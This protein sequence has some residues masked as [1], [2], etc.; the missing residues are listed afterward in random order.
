MKRLLYIIWS[1]VI[2]VTQLFSYCKNLAWRTP[3]IE[4]FLI[5]KPPLCT[6]PLTNLYTTGFGF[7]IKTSSDLCVIKGHT[8]Y[9]YLQMGLR[10]HFLSTYVIKMYVKIYKSFFLTIGW[11]LKLYASIK[12]LGSLYWY[13]GH[14][15][16]YY[17]N[18]GC[19]HFK[20]TNY[21]LVY[22]RE[23]S[24]FQ[25]FVVFWMLYAF[26]WVIPRRIKFRRRGIT[27]K[28]AHNNRWMLFSPLY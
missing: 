2:A 8:Q 20:Y 28:K 26:F 25:I 17:I 23:C 22:V 9:L 12:V 3:G 4:H 18:K 14:T 5:F 16:I 7:S 24:W 27:Q 21:I 11:V 6:T 13:K 15:Y 19:T 10:P 1:R